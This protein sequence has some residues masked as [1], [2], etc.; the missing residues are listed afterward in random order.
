VRAERKPKL[1]IH[2]WDLYVHINRD[3]AFVY[4]RVCVH[5][6]VDEGRMNVEGEAGG[7]F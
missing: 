7:D 5:G 3:C 2:T 6:G 4:V 1:H